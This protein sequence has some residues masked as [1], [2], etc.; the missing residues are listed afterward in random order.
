MDN[1]SVGFCEIEH[2]ADWE[3]H[4]WAPDL[5][6]LLEQA[7]RGMYALSQMRLAAGPRLTRRFEIPFTD[8]ESLL[9]DFLSELLFFGEDEEIAF[10]EYQLDFDGTSLKVRVGGAPIEEQSKEIKAV[11]YHKMEVRET[12]RGLE[13]NIVFDV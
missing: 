11:T 6:S 12:G 8:R 10:D 2:T 7:A 3:L 4:I 5:T 1:P 13:V 9:V